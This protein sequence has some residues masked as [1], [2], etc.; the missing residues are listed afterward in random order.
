MT[1]PLLERL[2]R[3]A[4]L[5]RN[6]ADLLARR[7]SVGEATHNALLEALL[8]YRELSGEA[9]RA[10][11]SVFSDHPDA[12]IPVAEIIIAPPQPP[13]AG[14][15][16]LAKV[17]AQKHLPVEL[18]SR[19]LIALTHLPASLDPTVVAEP[20]A[21]IIPE[22]AD[23][24]VLLQAWRRYTTENRREAEFDYHMAATESASARHRTLSY[25]VLLQL[26]ARSRTPDE[27]RARAEAALEA[28]SSEEVGRAR[29]LVG[30]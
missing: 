2:S 8:G 4:V 3:E 23:E 10:L 24:P 11:E 13:P 18:R 19:A 14:A 5:P 7:S 27:L 9:V 1:S 16:L 6:S 22:V 20:Y 26:A 12:R 30:M 28:A 17:A 21:R 25:A 15:S 29:E